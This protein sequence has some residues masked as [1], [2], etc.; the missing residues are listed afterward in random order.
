[1]DMRLIRLALVLLFLSAPVVVRAVSPATAPL[2]MDYIEDTL[3]NGL[4]VVYAP[5]KGAT[6]SDSVVQVRVVYHVGSRDERADRQGFAHLF[7]H[8]MFRGSAHVGPQEHVRLINSVGGSCNG[9]T[10]HDV[11]SY[12]DTVPAN[13][14]EL[15]LWL[16]AGP[17]GGLQGG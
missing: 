3:D 11:T 15:A 12:F 2:P 5:V 9:Q 17:G 4:R 16:A 6:G 10:E 8:M 7:E 1:M 13:Q 14:L